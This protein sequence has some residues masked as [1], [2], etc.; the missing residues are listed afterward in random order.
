MASFVTNL[1]TFTEAQVTT[2][3]CAADAIK[4]FADAADTIP[5][6]GGLWAAIVGDNSLATFSGYLPDLGTN[7]NAFVTNLGTFTD[8]QV[9]TVTCAADA[10]KSLADAAD[11]IP[12]EG[13]FWAAIVGDN[14]LSTFSSYLPGL[15]TNL[16][17]FVA[18]LGTFTDAQVTSVSSAISA[19]NAFSRLANADLESAKKNLPGFG[20]K[21][22]DFAKDIKS[23]IDNMPSPT[24][25][26]S[27]TA[28]VDKIINSINNIAGVDAN[29]AVKFT[30]SL[31]NIG[32]DG[33]QS[34]IDA[35]T[36]QATK[37]DARDAAIELMDT[38]SGGA[39]Q[40]ED[41]TEKVFKSIAGA[42]ARSIK[43][44]WQ[45]FY[46]AGVYLVEG[47]AS[48]ISENS[49]IASAKAAAMARAAA[50]AAEE[51]LD[52][53]SPSKVFRAIGYSVPE[54][55]AQGIDRMGGMVKMSVVGMTDGAVSS[56]EKSISKIADAINTDIDAQPTIRP[57][58][59]LSDVREGA[60]TINGLFDTEA[61]VG[62]LSRVGS[63]N[64]AM[65][66]TNQNGNSDDVVSA[67]NKLNKDLSAAKG[68]TYIIEGITYDEGSDV[69]DAIKAITRYAKIERR[70]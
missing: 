67:I 61:R 52:I 21:L 47:L 62:L 2:V 26:N 39:K 31:K 59:D 36:S 33:V 56:V 25:I 17:S 57:V 23:F 20:D 13:G 27:A 32:K 48:G 24:D 16:S 4:I 7:M 54:G 18:N 14:S 9:T 10:I 3:T 30:D 44:K 15:G 49:Y 35:F 42:C 37:T 5:N 60:G 1:G 50:D 65:S 53:N 22:P 51:E 6:E 45:S 8:A 40:R 64:T 70:M 46:D 69:A 68:D 29:I 34:F 19:I 38:L 63:I 11:T 55:F 12:N 43:D 58:L 41:N 66:R 28:Q